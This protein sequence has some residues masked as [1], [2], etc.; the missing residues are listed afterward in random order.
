MSMQTLRAERAQINVRVQELAVKAQT[1]LLSEAENTEFVELEGRFS[2]LTTQ[3]DT[4]ERADRNE[5]E[6]DSRPG[7]GAA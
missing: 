6:R 1:D 4:L 3:I 5:E 7:S 2:G